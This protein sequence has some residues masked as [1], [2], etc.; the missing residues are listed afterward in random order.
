MYIA[1]HEQDSISSFLASLRNASMEKRI[2]LLSTNNVCAKGTPSASQVIVVI[3]E[4]KNFKDSSCT[5]GYM[6]LHM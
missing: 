6:Q 3:L 2:H 1:D 4:M 5:Y